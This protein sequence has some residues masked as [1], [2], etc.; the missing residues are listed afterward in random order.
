MFVDVVVFYLV[1][2][3][4]VLSTGWSPITGIGCV[5]RMLVEELR[6]VLVDTTRI[7]TTRCV[8]VDGTQN[9]EGRESRGGNRLTVRT[10]Y[11]TSI[12]D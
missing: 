2:G 4:H 1:V 3:G 5:Q 9:R 7:V 11:Q 6:I 12:D 10:N 8:P